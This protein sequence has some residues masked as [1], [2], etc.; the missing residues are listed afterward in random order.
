MTAR[1]AAAARLAIPI[2]A[3]CVCAATEPHLPNGWVFCPFRLLTGLPCP[4]CGMTRGVASL[5]RARWQEALAYHLFS[6][7]VLFALAT[8]IIVETGHALGLW[9]ARRIT[10]WALRPAPWIAFLGVCVV[11]GALRWCGIIKGPVS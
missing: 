8:W 3:L 7:L 1:Q 11:Y 2:G 5:L 9:H 10:L 6:P 4:F